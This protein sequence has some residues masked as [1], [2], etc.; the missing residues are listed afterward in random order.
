MY[1]VSFPHGLFDD[2][3]NKQKLCIHNAIEISVF[4]IR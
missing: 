2:Y 1:Q 4:L 3:K